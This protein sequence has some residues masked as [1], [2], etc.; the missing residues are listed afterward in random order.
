MQSDKVSENRM[1][2]THIILLRNNDNS[3]YISSQST[4][5]TRIEQFWHE[6]NQN[7]M[8]SF[9]Q[10]FEELEE[11]NLLDTF[12]DIDL[13]TLH[14]VCTDVIQNKINTFKEYSNN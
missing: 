14:H 5:N 9:C 11:L 3:R 7:A 1:I 4:Y 8:I 12:N 2:A 13:W 10:E 6:R